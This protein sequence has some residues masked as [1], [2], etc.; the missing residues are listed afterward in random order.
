MTNYTIAFLSGKG[1]SGKTTLALSMASL[2]AE[3]GL[4]VLLIDCD[5]NTNGAT[6]FF[7]KELANYEDQDLISFSALRSPSQWNRLQE[8]KAL[9]ASYDFVPSVTKINTELGAF[10]KLTVSEQLMFNKTIASF[11]KQYNFILFDC[12]AGYNDALELIM[13]CV[14][15]SL[16][17]M[18]ADA[19]SSSA[20]RALFWRIGRYMQNKDSFQIFNKATSEEREIYSKVSGGT[21]FTNLGCISFDWQVRKAFSMLNAPSINN[22]GLEYIKQLYQLCRDLFGDSNTLN[23]LKVF[24][25]KIE[26]LE[27]IEEEDKVMAKIESISDSLSNDKNDDTLHKRVISALSL[28]FPILSIIA[29]LTVLIIS[30]VENGFDFSQLTIALSVF[31]ILAF[32]YLSFWILQKKRDEKYQKTA[33]KITLS[34]LENEINNIREKK[35]SLEKRYAQ[36]QRTVKKTDANKTINVR[37]K[38]KMKD[39]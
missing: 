26:I 3:C 6:Y 2:L 25:T 13:P 21:L 20:A 10:P 7:E 11:K 24:Q 22:L 34:K 16:T 28:I 27:T 37:Q 14:D 23:S 4:K 19:V 18:E 17:V 1:G 30:S 8:M 39:L 9:T 31:F 15:L 36:Q 35:S 33:K 5:L 32:M 29:A 12:Q 38:I